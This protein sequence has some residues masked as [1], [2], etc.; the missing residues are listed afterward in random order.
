MLQAAGLNGFPMLQSSISYLRVPALGLNT[1]QGFLVARRYW[2]GSQVLVA[3]R[4]IFN[5]VF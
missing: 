4:I 1:V 5:K 3:T 2:H